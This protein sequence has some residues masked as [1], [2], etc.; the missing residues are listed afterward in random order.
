MKRLLVLIF[1]LAL[2]M[3]AIAGPEDHTPGAVYKTSANVPYYLSSFIFD[4]ASISNDGENLVLE[5]R[6]GNLRGNFKIINSSRHNED[7]V[8]FTAEKIII[9][10]WESGCGEG[11]FAKIT[12]QGEDHAS[13]GVD[14]TGFSITVEY[15]TVNDTCHSTPFTEVV[16]YELAQ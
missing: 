14:A 8:N 5:A 3:I 13:L 9:N 11:E 6:Y 2:P 1:L 7:R 10:K 15:T 12:I 4:S 16:K